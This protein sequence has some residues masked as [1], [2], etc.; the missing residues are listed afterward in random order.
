MVKESVIVIGAGMA[1]LR[2]ASLLQEAGLQVTVLEARDRI[3]GR[4]WTD[5]SMPDLALD[6]GANWIHG[7]AGNPLYEYSQQL[8]VVTQ[9]W[10]YDSYRAYN[11][12]GTTNNLISEGSERF[13][14]AL[15]RAVAGLRDSASVQTL[16]DK[17]AAAGELAAFSQA[18]IALLAS[19]TFSNDYG[20]DASRLSVSALDE[21][22][23]AFGDTEVV[24]PHGYDALASAL[25]EGLD[26][27]LNSPVTAV[28][29]REDTNV[30][31]KTKTQNYTASRVLITV[32]LGV[33]K[34]GVIEFLP[35]LPSAQVAAID[36]LEM[37]LLDKLYLRF[38]KGF[39]ESDIHNFGYV[40]EVPARFPY[41]LNLQP[42]T[43]EPVLLAFNGGE[44]ALQ[45]EGGTDADVL[46]EA[47]G[48]LR[49]IYGEYVPEPMDYRITR[50]AADPFSYGSYSALAM[51]ATPE[52]RC[53]LAA[54]IDNRIFFAGEAT[55]SQHPATVHGAFL[56][57]VRE[58]ELIL[59]L[60]RHAPRRKCV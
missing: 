57:G 35:A 3:G 56:S 38:D 16:I 32:P 43:G 51:G 48:V 34:A 59:L 37:G 21:G 2:A 52:M 45:M 42:V 18:E 1:G 36:A 22:G 49:S 28:D 7:I 53:D 4:T 5:R 27:V 19:Q 14:P 26:I 13:M 58:A 12:G 46:A 15:S 17:S 10:D 25:A 11:A 44:V 55:H 6:M 29:Y 24:F 41:W 30:V 23:E 31:V 9:Q 50:W 39:W 60:S 20:L 33:L 8:G 47:M 54:P 40:N